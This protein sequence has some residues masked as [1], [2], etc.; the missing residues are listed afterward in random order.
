[1]INEI[2]KKGFKVCSQYLFFN[3]DIEYYGAIWVTGNNDE[4]VL[5]SVV[6]FREDG[7]HKLYE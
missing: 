1:M 6:K 5:K 2:K 4:P 3:N 7:N